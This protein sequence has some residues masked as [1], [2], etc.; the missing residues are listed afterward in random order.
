MSRFKPNVPKQGVPKRS[1]LKRGMPKRGMLRNLTALTVILLVI[2]GAAFKLGWGTPSAF[3]ID[4]LIY[5]CPLGTLETA[6]ASRTAAPQV[7]ISLVLVLGSIVLFGRYFCSWICPTAFLR[8]F[9]TLDARDRRRAA[10]PPSTRARPPSGAFSGSTM[11]TPRNRWIA[12][13]DSRHLVLASALLSSAFFG[14]PVFCLICP[15]GLF[16]GAIFAIGRLFSI[17]QPSLEL[18][19]YPAI[20]GVELFAFKNWCRS[21]CPLGALLGLLSNLNPFFRPVIETE[22]CLRSKGINCQACQKICPEEID[23]PQPEN[24]RAPA[25]CIKCLACSDRCPVHAIHFPPTSA[26]F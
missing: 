18:V 14:F 17:Q 20:L 16:F 13:L 1:M 24:A 6:L 5:L 21:L 4:R 25:N 8:S 7:W 15:I 19:L 3:G 22:R 10:L 26:M 12:S 11:S 9:F 23:L 2:L